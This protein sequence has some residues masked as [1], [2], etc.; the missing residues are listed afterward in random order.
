MTALLKL[1]R[2][3]PLLLGLLLPGVLHAEGPAIKWELKDA[4]KQVDRQADDF[5]TA[6]ARVEIV[7]RKLSGEEVSRERG[8][9]LISRDGRIRVDTDAPNQRTYL[10]LKKDLYIHY[11]DRSQVEKYSLSKHKGRLEPFIRLGFTTTGRDLEDDFLLTSLGEQDIGDSR[12]LGLDLTPEASRTRE[13]VSG[14][15]L[16]INQASWMPTRQVISATGAAETMEIT[17]TH[18]ARNLNLN[19]DLFKTKWPRGTK[20][21]KM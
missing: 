5:E 1:A 11:P 4:L 12:T 3:S 7:R 21:K 10:L 15:Q 6:L 9:V 13:V 17:Y 19:P 14:V 2:F 8:T 16:W 20:T 18:T